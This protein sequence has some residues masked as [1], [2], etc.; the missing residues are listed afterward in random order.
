MKNVDFF[1]YNFNT[2]F[3]IGELVLV[4]VRDIRNVYGK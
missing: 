1:Y 2:F 3:G 4:L